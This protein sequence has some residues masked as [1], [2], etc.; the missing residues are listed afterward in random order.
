MKGILSS[1]SLLRLW[2]KLTRVWTVEM[3][4]GP[5]THPHT[6]VQSVRPFETEKNRHKSPGLP[7]DSI[8]RAVPSPLPAVPCPPLPG[9]ISDGP[10]SF[11]IHHLRLKR[12]INETHNSATGMHQIFTAAF[13][14]AERLSVCRF[15]VSRW[16]CAGSKQAEQ[17]PLLDSF[18]PPPT[19]SLPPPSWS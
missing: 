18:P 2:G 4:T 16:V 13:Q 19:L 6:R 11:S 5:R 7:H 12:L 17:G 9:C 10:F 14:F 15:I 1:C 3:K 8:S